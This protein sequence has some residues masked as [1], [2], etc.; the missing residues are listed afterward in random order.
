MILGAGLATAAARTDVHFANGL[1]GVMLFPL[2]ARAFGLIASIRR[3]DGV[4]H[5]RGRGSE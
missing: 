2:V 3:C 4:A 1:L 5:R